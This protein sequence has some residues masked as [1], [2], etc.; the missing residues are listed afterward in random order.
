MCPSNGNYSASVVDAGLS[1]LLE[2]KAMTTKVS[3][4]IDHNVVCMACGQVFTPT[5]GSSLW[6]QA[7]KR[8]EKY[9]DALPVIGEECGCVPRRHC[10]EAPFRV[11]GYDAMCVDFDFPCETFT[12]A[13]RI[14]RQRKNE[15]DVVFITGVSNVVQFAIN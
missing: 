1:K 15:G 14:Y 4:E 13:V 12:Q 3:D 2:D 10:P 9:L 7:K 8:A 11:F 5:V 6:W